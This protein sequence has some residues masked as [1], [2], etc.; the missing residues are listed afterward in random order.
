M[1]LRARLLTVLAVVSAAG[2]VAA[3]IATYTALRS[4]LFERVDRS[5]D[6]SASGVRARSAGP[7]RRS[8]SSSRSCAWEC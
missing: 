8:S 3:D 4:S 5:L 1:S 2:L 6:S 7:A